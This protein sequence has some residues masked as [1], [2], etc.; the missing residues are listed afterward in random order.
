V[1][2]YEALPSRARQAATSAGL[3]GG[4]TP[5]ATQQSGLSNSQVKS[6]VHRTSRLFMENGRFLLKLTQLGYKIAAI[7]RD[8][9]H[10]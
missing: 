2:I 7:Q 8:A 9:V 10:P 6:M 3:K 1:G 4:T 5:I